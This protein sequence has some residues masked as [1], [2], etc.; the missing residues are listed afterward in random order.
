VVSLLERRKAPEHP[1]VEGKATGAAGTI[2]ALR[3]FLRELRKFLKELG[4]HPLGTQLITWG[5]L[6]I[7]ISLPLI[8]ISEVV[9]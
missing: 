7:V 1:G 5:V 9:S 3:K 4:K 2:N 8:G 6:L